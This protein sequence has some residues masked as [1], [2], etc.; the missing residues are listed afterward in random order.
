MAKRLLEKK[1]GP[2]MAHATNPFFW[3]S[4]SE[5][6]SSSSTCYF[7]GGGLILFRRMQPNVSFL[8]SPNKLAGFTQFGYR[9]DT[10]W[11][12]EAPLGSLA[13]KL[14]SEPIHDILFVAW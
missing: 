14:V 1:I 5:A 7:F 10:H 4:K 3:P 8:P 6:V 9:S 12:M 13:A 2:Q 11:Q